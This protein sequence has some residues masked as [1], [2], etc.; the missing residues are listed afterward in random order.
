M[1][2]L[3]TAILQEPLSE[4]CDRMRHQKA[5]PISCI[6]WDLD[7]TLLDFPYSQRVALQKCFRDI[8]IEITEE[9]ITRYSQ[10]NDS[11]W[12]RLELG[13]VT[14]EELRTG[15][16]VTLFSEYGI[17]GV[18]VEAFHREYEKA[19]GSVF[20]FRDDGMSVV[21]SLSEICRQYVITNGVSAVAR[22][23]Y[24]ISGL[25]T[26]M[27]G[28]FISEEVGAPKPRPEFFRYCL[29]RIP[30]KDK[31][32]ILIVGDSLTSDIKGGI[33]MEIPTC[34]YHYDDRVNDTPWIPRYEITDLHMV[35]EI[36]A[37]A[38]V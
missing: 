37:P 31:S 35:C 9:Q 6:L 33:Q 22:N 38:R 29:E 19:L 15:R 24:R 8:G 27:D 28:I 26:V 3:D 11:Y 4:P 1:G 18:D 10:I 16:F 30:E 25:E 7:D 14:R 32:R 20:L 13:K 36:V 12:K 34:W 17:Q 21:R 5:L 2:G 23:K